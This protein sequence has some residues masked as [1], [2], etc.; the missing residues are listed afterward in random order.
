MEPSVLDYQS[1]DLTDLP[2]DD[3]NYSNASALLLR[4][5]KLTRLDA[6]NLPPNLTYLDLTD[7]PDLETVTGTFPET[8]EGLMLEGTRLTAL[9]PVPSN[10]T[11]LA[12]QDTPIGNQLGIKDMIVTKREIQGLYVNP[13]NASKKYIEWTAIDYTQDLFTEQ[14]QNEIEKYK[15]GFLP[16]HEFI[17]MKFEINDAIL[18]DSLLCGKIDRDYLDSSIYNTENLI[19]EKERDI[20]L[21]FCAFHINKTYIYIDM[22]CSS[23]TNK[24]GGSRMINIVF[25]YMRGHKNIQTIKLESVPNAIGFYKKKGFRLLECKKE[26]ELCPMVFMRS[27][28]T[29]SNSKSKKKTR[30][31]SL[32]KSLSRFRSKSKTARRKTV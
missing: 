10:L 18:S 27:D 20:V 26:L 1:K 21:G 7:N 19:V 12:I 8:L 4:D 22:I 29:V 11:T 31:N 28:L 5:N 30:S 14:E 3:P 2:T 15:L 24:G 16:S 32:S 13:K 17:K 25:G 6:S 23:K 9:P